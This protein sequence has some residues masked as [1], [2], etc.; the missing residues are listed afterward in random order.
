M[1]WNPLKWAKKIYYK[2]KNYKYKFVN[3]LPEI[4]ETNLIYIETNLDVPWQIV[5]MCPCGCKKKF[6]YEF[7]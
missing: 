2:P 4:R 6:A 3:E 1:K 5:M 7:N